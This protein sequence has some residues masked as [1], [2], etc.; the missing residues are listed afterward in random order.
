MYCSYVVFPLLPTYHLTEL[1][2]Q[3]IVVP[4]LSNLFPHLRTQLPPRITNEPHTSRPGSPTQR[5]THHHHPPVSR[6]THESHCHAT[7]ESANGGCSAESLSTILSSTGTSVTPCTSPPSSTHPSPR[8]CAKHIPQVDNAH[9]SVASSGNIANTDTIC[10]YSSTPM[11]SDSPAPGRRQG[12]AAQ[13]G[14]NLALATAAAWAQR[15]SNSRP[16]PSRTQTLP[17]PASV[18]ITQADVESARTTT[19]RSSTSVPTS[20]TPTPRASSDVDGQQVASRGEVDVHQRLQQ[21]RTQTAPVPSTSNVPSAS[22]SKPRPHSFFS[23]A[24]LRRSSFT[25]SKLS[26]SS[27]GA[28][29]SA[30]VVPCS[31]S[32]L[33]LPNAPR[34]GSLNSIGSSSQQQQEGSATKLVDDKKSDPVNHQIVG[35]VTVRRSRSS[36]CKCELIVS[37]EIVLYLEY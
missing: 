36:P 24:H 14:G 25:P 21:L 26:H 18:S 22:S 37:H 35:A 12:S 8:T 20:L 23:L 1:F 19:L 27:S 7:S 16:E 33:S 6:R 15:C 34:R 11:D 29:A 13:S 3:S 32:S 17:A 31:P 9:V 5:R 30:S 2:I 28:S 4:A 10:A